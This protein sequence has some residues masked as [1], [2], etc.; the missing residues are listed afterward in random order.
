MKNKQER[1]KQF[2]KII[3]TI[4]PADKREDEWK[5]NRRDGGKRERGEE[6]KRKIVREAE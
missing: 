3:V 4:F 2:Y 5:K 6:E 1:R